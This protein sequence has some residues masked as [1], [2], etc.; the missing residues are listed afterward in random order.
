[1]AVQ[2]AKAMGFRV[3]ALARSSEKLELARQLGAEMTL[4]VREEN[5]AVL[6]ERI[7][8]AHA[9]L[10]TAVSIPAFKQSLSTLRRHGTCSLV[11]IPPGDFPTPILDVVLKRLTIRGSIVGTR[12]DMKEALDFAAQGKIKPIIEKQSL[13]SINESFDRLRG[14]KVKGRIVLQIE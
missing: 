3:I 11:G 7:G 14:G 4:N 2:Y 10:V 5:P 9:A 12:Q 6:Q 13:D 1:M 8:G